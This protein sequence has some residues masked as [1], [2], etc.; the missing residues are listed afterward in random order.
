[1]SGLLERTSE[2][3][4]ANYGLAAKLAQRIGQ[5]QQR[6]VAARGQAAGAAA[7]A[8]AEAWP[9]SSYGSEAGQLG[10]Q[11]YPSTSG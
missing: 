2:K 4:Q 11:G 1:V 9:S 5:L 3:A 8:P 10:Y 7:P 6:L